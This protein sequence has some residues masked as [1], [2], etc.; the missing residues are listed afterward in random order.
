[1]IHVV[2]VNLDHRTFG[3]GLRLKKEFR[4]ARWREVSEMAD[5]VLASQAGDRQWTADILSKL[6][7]DLLFLAALYLIPAM[8][9]I[10]P[11]YSPS[12]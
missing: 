3:N 11:L 7:C 2:A 6:Q 10:Q 12:N 9:Q 5:K 1:M 8:V 4:N